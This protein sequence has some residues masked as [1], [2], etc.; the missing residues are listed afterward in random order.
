MDRNDN[1]LPDDAIDDAHASS[2]RVAPSAGEAALIAAGADITGGAALD[3]QAAS[4][5][6][7]ALG[8]GANP[9]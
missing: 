7:A 5:R 8:D 9:V 6:D 4:E 3:E 2:T 1:R